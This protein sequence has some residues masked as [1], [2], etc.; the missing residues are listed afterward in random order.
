MASGREPVGL[1]AHRADVPAPLDALVTELLAEAAA[2][3]PY[4]AA[5]V[6]LADLVNDMATGSTPLPPS[7]GD[8]SH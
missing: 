3:R 4:D 2:D 8:P 1:R 6:R 7:R 5:E